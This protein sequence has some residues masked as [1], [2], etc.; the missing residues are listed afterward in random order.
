M[1]SSFRR[2]P[3]NNNYL[4][5]EADL[6]GAVNKEIDAGI[7]D[8]Q[9][10]YDQMVELEKL[11]YENRDRNLELL[12]SFTQ[13]AGALAMDIRE[14]NEFRETYGPYAQQ[15]KEAKELLDQQEE[16]EKQQKKIRNKEK[17]FGANAT[18]DAAASTDKETKETASDAA[19]VFLNGS[20]TYNEDRTARANLKDFSNIYNGLLES[21]SKDNR[22]KVLDNKILNDNDTH[23]EARSHIEQLS[24]IAMQNFIRQRRAA[25]GK[26][27]TLGEIRKYLGPQLKT[28]ENNL[29][30]KW[31][32]KRDSLL[33]EQ[34]ATQNNEEVSAMVQNPET[35][36]NDMLGVDGWITSRKNQLEAQGFDSA[37]ASAKSFEEFGDI[38]IPMFQDVES[39]V[40]AAIG[41]IILNT[42]F[43][44]N[45]SK[46]PLDSKSA[47]KGA[48][49]LAD[50]IKGAVIAYD[51]EAAEQEIENREIEMS[52]WGDKEHKEFLSTDP[53]FIQ[54]KQYTLDFKEK[55]G[56]T[57][58]A[59]LPPFMKNMIAAN[60]F[61]DEQVIIDIAARRS[62]NLPI[63]ESMIMRIKDPDKRDAQMQFVNTPELG[64]F[65]TDEANAVDE[66]I[67]AITKEA[68]DLKDLNQAKT[69]QYLVTRDNAKAFYTARFKELVV[70]GQSR[71]TA[72]STAKRETLDK[73]EKGDFDQE[74]QLYIDTQATLD[75]NATVS[76]LQKDASLIYSTEAWAGE[77]PHLDV[78]AEYVRSGGQTR[79]PSY[80][81]RFSDIK[82]KGGTYLTPEEVFETRLKKTGR[83]KDGKIIEIPERKELKNEDGTPNVTE[84]NKLLHKPNATKTLDVASKG[85]NIEWMIK[86]MP[87]NSALN[88][89]MFIR[90]L[91]TNIQKHHGLLGVSIPH[92]QKTT[93]STED[94]N[95]LLEAVPELREAPFLNPNTLSTA[96]I[97]E[98]LN[99]NI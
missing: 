11:R 62:K 32:L 49:A 93:L 96:A 9:A 46:G 56:I 37:Y 54:V 85:N 97:N 30:A 52:S 91:E 80:Y 59:A 71:A 60:Y 27:L 12:S 41:R 76:A 39:G 1:T 48:R 8:T 90:Q 47:P 79:Y 98:M 95:T 28:T 75:L 36:A 29:L 4:A 65:T 86:T 3:Q 34:I 23:D 53:D 43:Q 35:M 70:G 57:D 25:G 58:D 44:F 15:W 7:K 82:K 14:A 74:T 33:D 69:D 45:G 88:A 66:R 55:F 18:G 63:T 2:Q 83:L 16:L 13:K 87:G 22:F 81:L 19:Y 31:R 94:S 6:S 26:E 67:I 51:R 38:L 17:E 99:L 50:R 77:D 73:M 24:L 42:V 40:D 61:D 20:F 84:Q 78:A 21:A 72:F 5:T 68:K 92:K 89:E 10:F 64:A